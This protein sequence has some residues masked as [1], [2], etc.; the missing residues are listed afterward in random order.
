MSVLSFEFD[1]QLLFA[2]KQLR[3]YLNIGVYLNASE[4]IKTN[5]RIKEEDE[6]EVEFGPWTMRCPVKAL[7]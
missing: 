1:S 4:K 3:N 7:Y 6:E 5:E 2:Q